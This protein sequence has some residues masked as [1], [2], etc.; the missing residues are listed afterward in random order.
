MGVRAARIT[1]DNKVEWDEVIA[2]S[3]RNDGRDDICLT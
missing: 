3:A 1:S 2:A